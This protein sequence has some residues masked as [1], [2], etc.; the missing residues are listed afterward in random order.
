MVSPGLG[1]TY[2][3]IKITRSQKTNGEQVFIIA[4]VG[5][6][7]FLVGEGWV[8]NCPLPPAP[9]GPTGT[10]EA[11]LYWNRDIGPSES[12]CQLKLAAA[13]RLHIAFHPWTFNWKWPRLSLLSP[14]VCQAQLYHLATALLL[15][16]AL[17]STFSCCLVFVEC[18]SSSPEAHTIQGVV[19]I[20]SGGGR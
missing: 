3:T 16:S 19:P 6:A 13:S 12:D 7:F 9:P 10:R 2:I 1:L 20:G 4:S 15:W 18:Y 17:N 8:A 11:A 5:F 14:S